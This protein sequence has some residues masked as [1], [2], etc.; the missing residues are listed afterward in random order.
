ML[1]TRILSAL[2]LIPLVVAAVYLG[3]LWFAGFVAIAAG[4]ATHEFCNMARKL[5]AHPMRPAAIG[6]AA[7]LPLVAL[8]PTQGLGPALFILFLG[9]MMVARVLRQ[10]QDGFLLDW[11]ATLAGAAYVGG[12]LSHLVLLRKLEQGII[13]VALV[14]LATWTTDTAAYFIGTVWGRHSLFPKVSPRKT[15][16]GTVAGLVG[17]T[18]LTA[19]IGCS[20]LHLSPMAATGLGVLISLAVT[21]GDLS[22]S[23]LKRQA[24][25]KDSGRLIPGHG[26]ALDR[27]DSLLFAGVAV[28]YFAIWIA[29]AR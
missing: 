17:G 8:V 23:L 7:L 2:V 25:V 6:V 27:I 13:W 22:E 19:A 14:F 4:L 18:A 28:Y 11:S 12:M 10:D 24:G 9:G 3:G 29:L 1:R 20:F 21:F 15:V 16:E 26:G 5:G